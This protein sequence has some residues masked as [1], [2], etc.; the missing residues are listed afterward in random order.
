MSKIRVGIFFGGPSREREISFAGG[1]TVYDNLDKDL[2]EPVPIFVDSRKTL[3]ELDWQYL[4][5]G[6]IRDFY[7]P[8]EFV[9]G[10]YQV[11]MDSLDHLT[12][13]EYQACIDAV[14]QRID[15][16]AL[17]DKI[18]VAFLAL[19]GEYGEDGQ[20]QGLLAALGIPYTGSGILSCALG[21]DKSEQKKFM[22][23]AQFNTP[24]MVVITREAWQPATAANWLSQIADEIGYPVVIRP[25]NQ[26]SSIGVAIIYEPDD[27]AVTAAIDAAFFVERLDVVAWQAMSV[28][29]Q[30]TWMHH[31]IDIRGGLGLPVRVGSHTFYLPEELLHFLQNTSDQELYLEAVHAEQTVIAEA[32]IDGKEFSTIV[33]RKED[34]KA[35]ALP[36]TEIRKGDQMYDYRSKY[37]PGLA[38]KIT[39]IDLPAQQITDIQRETERLFDY[40]SFKTYARIDGFIKADGSI[41]LNDPNTTSGMMPSSFFFHQ[42]AEVG[43]SPSAFLTYIIE[44]SIRER[45]RESM[46]VGRH[47]TLEHHL[48]RLLSK[49]SDH[50]S[51]KT[52]VAV[53]LGGYSFERHISVESGRNIYEK[54]SSS[55]DY[56]PIPV[57]LKGS[58]DGYALYQI[59]INL[60]LKDN[61]DDISEKI[62]GYKVHPITMAVRAA[63]ATTFG[64]YKSSGAVEQPVHLTF[65]ELSDKV[66]AVFIALHGRPGEDGTLQR[67]LEQVGLPYN[68][69]QYQS[70]HIT[71]NKYETLQRLKQAGFVVADQVLI[72]KHVFGRD[73]EGVLDRLQETITY[74]LIAK[75]VDDGCSSAVRKINTREDLVVYLNGIFRD[76]P[77]LTDEQRSDLRLSYN[78]EFPA[79]DQVLIES[80][81]ESGEAAH[82]LEITG[83]LMT[84]YDDSGDL[85]YQMLEPSE[86]LSGGEVLS[87]EE[88]FLA[89]EGQNITPARY[90]TTAQTYDYNH[91]AQQVKATLQ[92]AAELLGVTGYA[93]IDAFVRIHADGRAETIIIEVNSLP[94][95]TPA[96]CIFHQTAIAGLKPVDFIDHIL[97]FGMQRINRQ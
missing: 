29:E 8:V 74:P 95:M 4:Y 96:T 46:Q 32:F 20:L 81:I 70:S 59:P 45:G 68:G 35:L 57:F 30:T 79:K 47:Q 43:L 51:T 52:K 83:G 10:D 84:S 78:E 13:D 1:R 67:E 11:Y 82:F 9:D 19:H 24:E 62:E 33:I 97:R 85:V 65:E 2:F 26:G 50:A 92:G 22:S 28:E 39:P 42:A 63:G 36:P 93:R 88:K 23:A 69:S 18:D 15:L 44:M 71:I 90:T 16:S 54:L 73:K 60:L 38:R 49:K 53:I 87:L 27:D 12:K 55:A 7:P 41:Y 37:L 25:A 40:L 56:E 14:G 64:R 89:G 5:K 91:I 66:D 75:P 3:I 86:A 61:A 94:G 77:E 80:L 76:N 72:S 48:G 6:T 21:M 34:G 58:E 17:A 31:F